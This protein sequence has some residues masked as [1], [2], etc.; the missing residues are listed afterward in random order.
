[1]KCAAL[2]PD[3]KPQERLLRLIDKLKR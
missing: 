3:R 2:L 1:M